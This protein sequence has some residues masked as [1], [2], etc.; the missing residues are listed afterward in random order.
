MKRA[1]YAAAILCALGHHSLAQ[2]V[3][4]T[5]DGHQATGTVPL[6]NN[7]SGQ[8]APVS[9]SNPLPISGTFSATLGGFTPTP[10]Y[11]QLSSA[12]TTSQRVAVPTGIVDVVYNTSANVA[13]CT[14]GSSSV[15]ATAGNDVIQANSW[16]AFTVPA[17]ATDIACI[18]PAGTL[19]INISG[20]AGLPTGSGGGGGGP[21][22]GGVVT[23][24]TAANLNMTAVGP[25]GAALATAANQTT[26]NGSLSTI[27][28]TLGSPMQNSGGAVGLAAGSQ[29]VGKVDI[30][31][32]TPGTTNGIQ[33]NNAQGL[34]QTTMSASP[35]VNIASD[36]ST[37]NVALASAPLPSG[38]ATA[39]L[40][41][42]N[43]VG[44]NNFAPAPFT[45]ASS[46]GAGSNGGTLIFSAR[47]GAPGTGR[48]AVMCENLGTT[49]VYLGG[50]TVTATGATLGWLLPG[51]IGA[52]LTF[53]VTSALYGITS[54]ASQQI[55][56]S[57]LY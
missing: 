49:N 22:S 34:G 19:A 31:Q 10:S 15:T 40:Q 32:T 9:G 51:Y 56:C 17:G 16:V 30:D 23:Q 41:G 53:P 12:L 39:A 33:V 29:I 26:A 14:Y 7:G 45:I 6:T 2:I 24:P 50:T 13:Y 18:S 1:L 37:I 46:G 27:N 36:Q 21:S 42:A 44:A 28:A 4:P 57:E 8:M 52:T 43:P 3:F 48:I 55:V 54:S 25:S 5:P 38:A 47:T 11:S 35:T 20:G